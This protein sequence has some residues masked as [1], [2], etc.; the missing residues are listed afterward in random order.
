MFLT[1]L[2]TK[3][4]IKYTNNA[5]RFPLAFILFIFIIAD[6]ITITSPT[7]NAVKWSVFGAVVAF[8]LTTYIARVLTQ[9]EMD[10][11]DTK[12]M[13]K[14]EEKPENYPERAANR[15]SFLDN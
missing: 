13:T 8:A 5:V 3:M 7:W 11:F 12:L 10:I 9:K 2:K 6:K 15:L 4:V 1:P 14:P